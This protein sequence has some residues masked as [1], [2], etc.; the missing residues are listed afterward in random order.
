[1]E[2]QRSKSVVFAPEFAC[3]IGLSL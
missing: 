3:G 2:N 1:M